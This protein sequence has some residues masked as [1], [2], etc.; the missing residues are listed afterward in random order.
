MFFSCSPH[1]DEL[2]G[3]R[4]AHVTP[5]IGGD[6]DAA[7]RGE[8]FETRGEVD[9]MAV[10]VVRCND[11]VTEID[12]MRNSMRWFCGSTALR[13]SINRCTSSAHRPASTTLPN[14]TRAPSPV[15]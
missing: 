13:A 5:G 9:P 4:A 10:D 3:N 8:A 12:P 6:A 15:C 14:S 11:H 1:V 7:G 2:G